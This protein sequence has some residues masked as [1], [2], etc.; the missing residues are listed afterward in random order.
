M[1]QP[2]GDELRAH[3][4]VTASIVV[5]YHHGDVRGQCTA[6]NVSRGGIFLTSEDPATEGTRVYMRLYLPTEHPEQRDALEVIGIVARQ[7]PGV[8]GTP[9]GMGVHF[10]VAFAAT[11]EALARFIDELLEN[12]DAAA[13]VERME[14]GEFAVVLS[15]PEADVLLAN[16][17]L[18]V[19]DISGF[20]Q[21]DPTASLAK[22][23]RARRV[24]VVL[25]VV[26]AV[27]LG[28]YFGLGR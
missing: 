3:P 24:M 6:A 13:R 2:S 28:L 27:A 1:T 9:A 22:R 18:G 23:H 4:R 11:R 8:G 19:Q 15:G 5:D 25:L 26:M 7:V 17:A 12:P 20:F 21:F 14:T 16:R 10:E